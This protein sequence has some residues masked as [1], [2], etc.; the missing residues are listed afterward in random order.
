MRS[1][2]VAGTTAM[3]TSV[4]AAGLTVTD[5]VAMSPEAVWVAVIMAVPLPVAV[6]SPPALTVATPLEEL[7]KVEPDVTLTVDPSLKVPVTVNCEVPPI[8]KG[9]S[10]G[11][12]AISSRVAGPELTVTVVVAVSPETV[13]VTVEVPLPMAVTTPEV[14]TA[15]TDAALV[16]K[17]TPLVRGARVPSL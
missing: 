16:A 4:G 17:A 2:T 5:A 14:L 6:T 3:D 7:E 15:A 8:R 9:T 12:T 10:G 11:R 1:G 13:A